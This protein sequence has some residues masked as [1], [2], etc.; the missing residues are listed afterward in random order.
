ML[1]LHWNHKPT[2]IRRGRFVNDPKHNCPPVYWGRSMAADIRIL[3]G[4]NRISSYLPTLSKQCVVLVGSRRWLCASR[5]THYIQCHFYWRASRRV[6]VLYRILNEL[7]RCVAYRRPGIRNW[8]SSRTSTVWHSQAC[9]L[10]WWVAAMQLCLSTSSLSPLPQ[11]RLV[12]LLHNKPTI[13]HMWHHTLS[14]LC[15]SRP[16]IRSTL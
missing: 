15:I 11:S 10:S 8:H 4:I 13:R 2:N 1:C 12:D 16:G 7:M 9:A 3:G 14:K 6:L 5:S